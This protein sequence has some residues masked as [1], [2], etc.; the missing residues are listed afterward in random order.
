MNITSVDIVILG[1]F[2]ALIFAIYKMLKTDKNILSVKV[3][4][5]DSVLPSNKINILHDKKNENILGEDIKSFV[6]EI[7]KQANYNLIFTK[8]KSYDKTFSPS[9]LLIEIR[10]FFKTIFNCFYNRDIQKLTP[11]LS[12][13]VLQKFKTEID[14]LNKNKQIIVADLVRIKNINIKDI[15][16]DKKK[17]IVMV[18][19]ITEQTA[20]LK[21]EN[22]KIIKGDDNKIENITDFWYITKDYSSK[23]PV[24]KL[25]KTIGE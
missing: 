18:E 12:N 24:W 3:I 11:Q 23:K 25:E 8:L 6:T 19:F 17:L 1:V 20:I 9:Q 15:K 22:D 7:E 14:E 5:L 10:E 13:T 4:K 16:L 2:V 21:D